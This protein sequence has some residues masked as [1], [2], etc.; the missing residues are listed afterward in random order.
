MS[1]VHLTAKIITAVTYQREYD[2]TKVCIKGTAKVQDVVF[3][4]EQCSSIYLAHRQDGLEM[5]IQ[6]LVKNV[7]E[8]VEN[9]VKAYTE[10]MKKVQETLKSLGITEI[11]LEEDIEPEEVDDIDD[12]IDDDTDDDE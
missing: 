7:K 4:K 2:T 11:E 3:T 12:C 9:M 8:T 1:E 10:N 5:V 6:E